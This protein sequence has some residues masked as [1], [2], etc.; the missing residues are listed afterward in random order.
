MNINF[1]VEGFEFNADVTI[2]PYIPAK[3]TGPWEFCYPEEGG[4]MDIESIELVNGYLLD[5][6]EIKGIKDKIINAAYKT[7]CEVISK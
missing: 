2:T 6:F 4:E 3:I 5:L 7:A 1:T